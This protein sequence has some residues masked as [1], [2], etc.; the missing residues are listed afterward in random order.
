MTDPITINAHS[1]IRLDLGEV[2]YF[3]PFHI[4]K[5]THD[6]DV[7]LCTHDHY[8]HFSPEDIEKIV[9]DDTVFVIPE[10]S[11]GVVSSKLPVDA[12]RILT[13][14]AGDEITVKGITIEAVAAYNPNKKFHP[15]ER[16]WVGYIAESKGVRYYVAG[17]TDVTEEAK[18]VKCNVALIPI[19]GTYTMTWQEGAE[20]IREIEPDYVVPTHYAD[21]VGTKEDGSAFAE[22]IGKAGI[23]TKVVL[24]I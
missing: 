24:K 11:L 8:D 14:K 4:T 6:A 1:S 21:I 3:D 22:A 9:K 10:S 20:L 16:G 5:E 7:I 18:R 2:L 12:S 15:K 13:V 19:G 17:D 23:P